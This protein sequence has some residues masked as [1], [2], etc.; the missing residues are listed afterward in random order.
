MKGTTR[1]LTK[2]SALLL[3]L[4]EESHLNGL[5]SQRTYSLIVHARGFH[6]DLLTDGFCS[7]GL[8]RMYPI[9][10]FIISFKQKKKLLE[11]SNSFF[12]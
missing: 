12:P 9:F 7:W 11:S 10:V 4:R 3:A 5:S 1:F 2:L 8:T 6:Q